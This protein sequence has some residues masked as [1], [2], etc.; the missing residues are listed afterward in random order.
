MNPDYPPFRL[1]PPELARRRELPR[2]VPP[3]AEVVTRRAARRQIA[4]NLKQ[5]ILPLSESLRGMA[6]NERRAVFYKLEHAESLKISKGSLSGTGLKPIAEPGEKFTLVIPREDNFDKLINRVEEFGGG[7]EDKEGQVPNERL[8]AAIESFRLGEPS[9]RLNQTLFEAYEEMVRKEW[10]IFEIEM[11]SFQTGSRQQRDELDRIMNEMEAEFRGGEYGEILEH[12][13]AKGTR[14][15]VVRCTGQVFRNLVEDSRWQRSLYWFDARPEFQRYETVTDGFN[16]S[17]L[18]AIKPPDEDAPIVC[19]VDSGVTAGNP[20]LKP[21]TREELLR[22]FLIQELDNPFDGYGHGSGVASLAAYYVLDTSSGAVNSGKVWIAGAR[23]LDREN[24]VDRQL[25]S[26]MLTE[27]VETF[28]PLGVRIFN[29]SVNITNRLWNAEA[30]RSVPRRSWVA[31]RIDQLSREHDVVFVVSTGNIETWQVADFYTAGKEYP[32]YFSADEASI[33]DPGQAALA[34]TVGAL[35]RTTRAVG[36]VGTARAIAEQNHP[37]PFT[38]CGP[39]INRE[40]KPELVELSGNYLID[41]DGGRVRENLGTSVAV[42]SAELSPALDYA[43]G[44]SL[45]APRAAHKLALL[46]SDLEALGVSHVSAPLLRAFIVNSAQYQWDVTEVESFNSSLNSAEP[47]QWLNILGYGT[48]NNMRATD[49]D[50]HSALFY[51]Q[52]TIDMNGIAYFS[53]PVPKILCHTERGKKRMTIT[54]AYSPDV[55]RWGLETYL[56]TN[57][58]WRLFRGDVPREDVIK[59]MSVDEEREKSTTRSERDGETE[60]H[61]KVTVPKDITGKLTGFNLRSRGTVQHDVFEWTEHRESFSDCAYTL[62]VAT[63]EKWGRSAPPPV[64]FAVVV[65]L[66][67]TTRTAEVYA[68]VR[69]ILVETET[70]VR[71]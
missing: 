56:G 32:V 1:P 2:F 41:G 64:P 70:R 5:M 50:R 54:I 36:D 24:K 9:D 33:L 52:G 67:D 60:R 46:L 13:E 51:Y 31:R 48:P 29:L 49:C 38:R 12:E 42:A 45:A 25:L 47:K 3:S 27:V 21:V 15:A 28:A 55:Q 65:R 26:K 6:D 53:I 68:E 4:D 16:F 69:N 40:I 63:S 18:G 7:K 61:S 34:L 30:K 62:A 39:G 10:V 22:S 37:A 57:M 43:A 66:E 20:F 35:S 44:T 23:I 19:I 71:V 59:A 58:K 14:R 8:V 11:I 17:R